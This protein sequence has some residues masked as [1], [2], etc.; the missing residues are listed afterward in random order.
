MAQVTLGYC[1]LTIPNA[2][3]HKF[4]IV[5][6][7]LDI[8]QDGILGSQ[9]LK[10]A[11]ASIC[12]E[13]KILSFNDQQIPIISIS[14]SE[15]SSP[16]VTEGIAGQG[17]TA[18]FQIPPR[19]EIF[20]SVPISSKFQHFS[21]GIINK[22]EL[23]KGVF[24]SESIIRIENAKAITSILNI[25][26]ESCEVILN[27]IEIEPIETSVA[28][29]MLISESKYKQ[30]ISAS[31]LNCNNSSPSVENTEISVADA[32]ISESQRYA[33]NAVHAVYSPPSSS[34][35][36]SSY[37]TNA[38]PLPQLIRNS[39][40]QSS[41]VNTQANR[42]ELL[43][44]QLRLDHLNSE[45][46]QSLL[47]VCNEYN[48]VF[49]LPGDV[50]PGANEFIHRIPTTND[51]PIS[52]RQYRYPEVH[53]SEVSKQV[54]EMLQKGVVQPSQSPYNFPLWVVPKKS[55]GELKYRIVIDYR[56]LNDITIGD[57]Y[58]IPQIEEI[59][60]SLG[61]SK[62]FSTLDLAS[63]FHQIKLHPDDSAKTA[64][65]TPY[66]HF[67]F[68]RVPFGLKNA[69]STFQRAM[70]TVLSGIQGFKAFVYMDD[71]VIHA[72]SL[73]NHNSKLMEIFERL[74]KFRLLVHPDKC[75]F[76]RKE[77]SYLGHIITE[78]GVK[79]DPGKTSIV[80]RYPT[81]QNQKQIK[82]FL[83]LIGFY[84]KFIN[85]FSD[86]AKPLTD[87][88]KKDKEF[89]WTSLQQHAFETLRRTLTTKP[90]LI[91][92]DF[93][94]EFIL[95]TDSSNFALGAILSQGEIGNDK[96]ISYASR[97]LNR[98]EQNYST[99]EREA[100]AI[101]WATNY[102][103]HYLYG[104]KF[105]IVTDHRPLT[106]LFNVKDP[107]SKLIRWRLKL[108]QYDYKIVY[109][110]GVQNSNADCLSR[111]QTQVNV[112]KTDSANNYYS[113]S[114]MPGSISS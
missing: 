41:A 90:L 14:K 89:L 13:N 12:Y 9:F 34:S 68:T 93:E 17:Q 25:N 61:N 24:L 42:I 95:T 105:T 5:R 16:N 11:K 83:G 54:N 100:L 69:P 37:Q 26:T 22:V 77:C 65:S 47:S 21:E 101:V 33:H 85:N 88:L 96:P 82:S 38:N 10:T 40:S 28:D 94:R 86:I 80:E 49:Y 20:V 72:N 6:N 74:R 36:E 8:K 53:K 113:F 56:K 46:L 104:R 23:Q 64:F 97:T 91:Y 99:T 39:G 15:E 87:L 111:I 76:L 58:P 4:H 70:D 81:P 112:L 29:M 3:K 52:I 59:L 79:P 45:E 107:G 103:R 110:P 66:G 31:H 78:F 7:D 60:E 2:G 75:E 108:E 114:N 19:T 109:K 92:P 106:W 71:I 51:N 43:K 67:E 30:S 32:I 63:G 35:Q 98:A 50:F 44:S 73:N 48:D 27:P 84:R 1:F 62:Y 55:S 18:R 102:F 57:K